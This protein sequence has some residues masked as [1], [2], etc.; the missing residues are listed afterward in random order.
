MQP[1]CVSEDLFVATTLPGFSMFL[2]HTHASN[3][4]DCHY[5]IRKRSAF[6]SCSL[7]LLDGS[8]CCSSGVDLMF[9]YRDTATVLLVGGVALVAVVFVPVS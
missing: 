5:A 6:T 2:Q 7:R 8:R 9:S 3:E 4:Q 1:P